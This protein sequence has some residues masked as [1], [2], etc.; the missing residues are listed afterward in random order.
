MLVKLFVILTAPIAEERNYP[1]ADAMFVI[2]LLRATHTCK[3][4]NSWALE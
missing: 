4:S 3:P 1:L 2:Y